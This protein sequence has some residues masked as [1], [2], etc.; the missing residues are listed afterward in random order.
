MINDGKKVHRKEKT[1]IAMFNLSFR[2]VYVSIQLLF[3]FSRDQSH[4]K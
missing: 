2:F 3:G 1:F 4:V